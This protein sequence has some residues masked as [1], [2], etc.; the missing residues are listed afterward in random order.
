MDKKTIRLHEE[1]T[2]LR[3]TLRDALSRDDPDFFLAFMARAGLDPLLSAPHLFDSRA[4]SA[5]NAAMESDKPAIFEA[6]LNLAL[7]REAANG[8]NAPSLV[9]DAAMS[10]CVKHGGASCLSVILR[11]NPRLAFLLVEGEPASV[12]ACE[13]RCSRLFNSIF[14]SLGISAANGRLPKPQFFE[15]LQ[16]SSSAIVASGIGSSAAMRRLDRI[17][18]LGFD[19]RKGLHSSGYSIFW[20]CG[21][22]PTLARDEICVA[23]LSAGA[24]PE[25][26]CR[27]P[28]AGVDAFFSRGERLALCELLFSPSH[29][30]LN[31]RSLSV[32]W[33]IS[34]LPS[35]RL[36]A[37]SEPLL[38]MP[39]PQ[40]QALLNK[41]NALDN[42]SFLLAR[43][44]QSK[45]AT[46]SRE[47][48]SENPLGARGAIRQSRP[49][50]L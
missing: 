38:S 21:N 42:A 8:V 14:D 35:E 19:W 3:S 20:L 17:L 29:P 6:I 27:R 32:R 23:M 46:A 33:M 50:S 24:S 13:R 18:S 25:A 39:F 28:R 7:S 34:N 40:M 47:G 15:I 36:L 12:K 22:D 37:L 49:R 16:R 44:E 4:D 2:K 41:N 43:S 5:M 48:P 26:P 45:I 31:S 30:F 10:F 9:M 1:H 11:R